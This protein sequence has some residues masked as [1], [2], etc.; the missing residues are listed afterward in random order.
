MAMADKTGRRTG[1]RWG[2][3][4]CAG[5]LL[6][7]V[8]RAEH[9]SHQESALTAFLSLEH[10]QRDVAADAGL[11]RVQTEPTADI[12]LGL[13]RQRLRLLG[14]FVVSRDEHEFERLQLGYEANTELTLWLGRFHQPAS[15]WNTL[16][17]HGAYLQT[18]ITRPWIEAWEDEHGVVPQHV[19]GV[20]GEW[21]HSLTSGRGLRISAGYGSAPTL[22]DGRLDPFD[23]FGRRRLA[24]SAHASVR[25]EWLPDAAG[26]TSIGLVASH[27][28]LVVRRTDQRFGTGLE[29]G[30]Y[31]V[32]YN[33]ARARSRAIGALYVMELGGRGAAALGTQ[34]HLASYLQ[35]EFEA[36]PRVS[37]YARH[38]QITG[39]RRSAY[40]GE[41]PEVTPRCLLVGSRLQVGRRNALSAELA[42]RAMA[43]PGTYTELRLQWSAAVP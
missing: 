13:R 37:L 11:S 1:S 40:L 6:F 28:E 43:G 41:F 36:S 16:H 14:E 12:I 7:P 3:F 9:A 5:A 27:A 31:G 22:R 2:W 33:L 29:H 42:R 10:I 23:Q 19:T 20:L 17:H 15:G 38:E 34:R 18:S 4:A 32:F 8:A 25:L 39:V 26:E 30:L 21:Q 24:S 35:Y